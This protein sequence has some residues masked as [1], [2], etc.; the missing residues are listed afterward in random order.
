MA[1]AADPLPSHHLIA[2]CLAPQC[3]I[4]EAFDVA[5]LP[6]GQRKLPAE[7]YSSMLRCRCGSRQMRVEASGSPGKLNDPPWAM[8]WVS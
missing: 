1:H 3:Q 7:P 4:K 2:R 5:R 8:I 6:C